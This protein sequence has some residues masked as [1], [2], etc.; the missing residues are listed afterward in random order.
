[1]S[2]N[3]FKKHI[4]KSIACVDLEY[5]KSLI[6]TKGKLLNYKQIEMLNSLRPEASLKLYEK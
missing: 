3:K 1:M 2:K 6:K 4:N 5:L